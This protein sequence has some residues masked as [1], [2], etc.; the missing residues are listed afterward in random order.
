MY[1]GTNTG[2]LHIQRQELNPR[3]VQYWKEVNAIQLGTS[4]PI[5]S[6]LLVTLP[7]C[8]ELWVGCGTQISII[9]IETK[10]IKYSF[11]SQVTDKASTIM[12]LKYSENNKEQRV[13]HYLEGLASILE[14][15]ACTYSLVAVYYVGSF[16]LG[17]RNVQQQQTSR[18]S[19]C[20]SLRLN[21]NLNFE[22]E[23]KDNAHENPVCCITSIAIIDNTLWVGRNLGDIGIINLDTTYPHFQKGEVLATISTDYLLPSTEMAIAIQCITE[24]DESSVFSLVKV[25][26]NKNEENITKVVFWEKYQLRELYQFQ[27]HLAGIQGAE[28][29]YSLPFKRSS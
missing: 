5:T 14:Y 2:I 8:S 23:S 27:K 15:N 6:M 26:K 3:K 29:A 9:S 11:T 25:L 7:N 24:N 20:K 21:M 10:E 13:F 16:T 22:S 12:D 17:R 1:I 18:K 4:T 28:K 19:L